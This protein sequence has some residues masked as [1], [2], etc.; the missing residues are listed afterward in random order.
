MSERAFNFLPARRRPSKPRTRGLTEV[1]GPYYSS[2][3]NHYFADLFEAVGDSIDTLKFAGGSFTLLPGPVL[4][5][6]IET[7]HAHQ[8]RVSTGGFLERVLS[9]GKD[10]VPPYLRECRELGFDIVEIS[11]GFVVL[12]LE[13]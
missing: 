6:L 4:R 12:D 5:E 1:R 11:A 9:Y 10:L 13:D 2:P 3:G 7:A 8:V